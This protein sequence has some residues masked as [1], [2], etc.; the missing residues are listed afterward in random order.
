MKGW[1]EREGIGAALTWHRCK[2]RL[3]GRPGSRLQTQEFGAY[4]LENYEPFEP[5]LN[6]MKMDLE[7]VNLAA[8]GL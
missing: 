1:C 7:K 5:G 3:D 4:P 2:Q 6:M 8:D